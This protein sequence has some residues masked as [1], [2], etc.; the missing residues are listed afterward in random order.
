[1]KINLNLPRG[2]FNDAYL[3]YLH[4][5]EKRY[6]VYYGGAGSGK[7]VFVA[8]K[9]LLKAMKEKRKILVVRKVNPYYYRV[10]AL[11]EFASLDK[12]VYSNWKICDFDFHGLNGEHLAGLDF[13]FSADITAFIA[14]ILDEENKV[15]YATFGD[16]LP[17]EGLTEAA[18]E[19]AKT[20]ALTGV[21]ADALNWAGVNEDEFQSSLDKCNTE[22]E[23]QALITET[24]NGLYDDAA[25]KY[26]T[27]AEDVIEANRANQR[28]QDTLA[29]IA[30]VLEPVITK[31]KSFAAD[32]L[33]R[34]ANIVVEHQDSI[35]KFV[36][37]IASFGNFIL[38]NSEL[39]ISGLVG[40][41]TG[42]AVF[43]V[44]SIVMKL[45]EGFKAMK[46]AEEGLTIAQAALNVVMNANPFILVASLVAGLVAAIITL[47]NT[48]ENFRNAVIKI[49]NTIKTK[50]I[51]IVGGIVDA[52]VNFGTN[53]YNAGKEIFTSV[54]NGL[55]SVWDSICSWVSEKVNWLV[56]KLAFWRSGQSEMDGSHRTGLREVPYD[57]YVAELHKGEMVLTAY[58]AK[59][60]QKQGSFASGGTQ[61][62]TNITV[63][64]Y[65]PKA[66]NEAESARQ[67]KKAQ[68][69]LA[70]GVA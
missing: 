54:W 45:V 26:R 69:E 25:E 22:Q 15:I 36:D 21:L 48:N 32:G 52:I 10:Y 4:S 16:S 38:D 35:D 29:T 12:L 2:L 42:L 19:T 37:A 39:I 41:G 23:R 34:I 28:F 40:I 30:G 11:G 55:K 60:Y 47:W 33:E 24:L 31:V 20:G 5:Y 18:N 70:L 7:S 3:S 1:M 9:L 13:G 59:Q 67:F 49:W 64:N 53:F 68:R 58:E 17:I 61:S 63:N 8:Q 43:N 46:A 56:D 6:E 66:L 51:E 62:N 50:T 44:A 14:S 57:G 27:N 65:S